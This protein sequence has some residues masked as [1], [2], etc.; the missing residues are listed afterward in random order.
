MKYQLYPLQLP[1]IKK[2][3]LRQRVEGDGEPPAAAIENM[4]DNAVYFLNELFTREKTKNNAWKQLHELYSD[5]TSKE[6]WNAYHDM[7]LNWAEKGISTDTKQIYIDEIAE[8][9]KRIADL[10]SIIASAMP[11]TVTAKIVEYQEPAA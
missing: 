9:K 3:V 11:Q 10:E 2:D 7:Q 4:K 6:Y 8:L 1:K 5:P